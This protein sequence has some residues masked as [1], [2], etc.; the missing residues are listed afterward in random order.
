M[1]N[2]ILIGVLGFFITTTF[3]MIPYE[4]IENILSFE[5]FSVKVEESF[6]DG[7]QISK[8]TLT[9][10]SW[11]DVQN[12]TMIIRG[13]DFDLKSN[14]CPEGKI[15]TEKFSSTVT[16]TLT[17]MKSKS[18][19]IFEVI[20]TPDDYISRIIVTGNNLD[21]YEWDQRTETDILF[22][23]VYLSMGLIGTLVIAGMIYSQSRKF[24]VHLG[25]NDKLPVDENLEEEYGEVFDEEDKKI[26]KAINKGKLNVDE[27]SYYTNLSKRTI[28]KK[29]NHMEKCGMF[30]LE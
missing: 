13:Y 9:N 12:M 1:N 10:I 25:Y 14:S 28:R 7:K 29:L 20:S 19:C 30:Y 27:I 17:E 22:N 24:H 6:I 21:K 2:V 4:T 8:I 26:I 18:E 5:D 15:V 3:W 16:F 11:N 23:Y